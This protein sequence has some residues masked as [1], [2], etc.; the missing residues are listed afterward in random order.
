M[1]YE[2][3]NLMDMTAIANQNNQI[4]MSL[5]N[6]LTIVGVTFSNIL[7]PFLT[8]GTDISQVIGGSLNMFVG[9]VGMVVLYLLR[10]HIKYHITFTN[11]EKKLP[12][13]SNENEEN[14]GQPKTIKPHHDRISV[15][16]KMRRRSS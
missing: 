5:S 12:S 8:A 6:L 1:N 13:G 4:P 10:N 2:T 15:K 3:I 7:I 9:G 11:I 16:T 14:E